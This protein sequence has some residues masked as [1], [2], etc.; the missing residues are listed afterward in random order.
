MKNNIYGCG[1]WYV[2]KQK[3]ENEKQKAENE[4][5]EPETRNQQIENRKGSDK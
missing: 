5:Q 2:R 4:K 1:R 3:A